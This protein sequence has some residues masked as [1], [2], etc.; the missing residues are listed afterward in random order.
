M[1]VVEDSIIIRNA[2]VVVVVAQ[3]LRQN[4]YKENGYCDADAT[5]A[6][7]RR[8]AQGWY[9]SSTDRNS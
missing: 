1:E 7:R 8:L 3:C 6:Q 5:M 9:R 2:V 4:L